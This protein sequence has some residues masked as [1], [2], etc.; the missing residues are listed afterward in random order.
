MEPE[1]GLSLPQA[2]WLAAGVAAFASV[3][4]FLLPLPK[5]LRESIT[6]HMQ[7]QVRAAG[8]A[9]WQ[10]NYLDVLALLI[11]MVLLYRLE[12]YGSFIGGTRQDPQVD[13]M[14]ILAPLSLLLGTAAIFLRVFPLF[15]DKAA[16][17]A[18]RGRG[19]PIVLAL[20]QASRDPRHVT[21]LVLLLMLAMALGIFSTSLDA[22]MARNEIDRSNYFA[23][24]D[25]RL[26]TNPITLNGRSIQGVQANTW[27]W[28]SE[29]SLLAGAPAPGLDILA[30]NPA[31]FSALA[32]FRSDF[33]DRPIDQLLYD[34]EKDWEDH[35][36][37]LPATVLPGK[38]AKMGLWFGLPFSLR[39][40]PDRADMLSRTRFEI[41][42]NS[43]DGEIINVEL[44]P[45][46]IPENLEEAWSFFQGD[47][48]DLKPEA[49]PLRLTSLWLQ[50]NGL[51]LG[52][53]EPLWLDDI[54][55][56]DR[57]T[58]DH[59]IV[60]S[61]EFSGVYDWQSLTQPMRLFANQSLSHS[62]NAGLAMY[63]DRTG[64]SPLRWYGVN[65]INDL[66]LQAIPA[67][68]SPKFLERTK[69]EV[70]DFV[71]IRIKVPGNIEW[72]RMTFRILG[73]ANYFPTMYE[74]K[75]AGFLVTLQKP[76]MEQIN[77][78]RF[79]P[80][81]SN[82]VLLKAGDS[83]AASQSL[84]RSGYLPEDFYSAQATLSD[85]RSN[86]LVIGLRSVT[87]FGYILTT[88]L[89]LVG[90]ASHFYLSTQ[91]R[92]SQYSILRALGLSP[93]QLYTTLL[94]EQFVL[95]VSGLT[96]GTLLGILLNQLIL[97]GLPLRLGDLDTIPPFV[98]QND[99]RLIFQV[100]LTLALAFLIS[101]G[102]AIFLLWK[103]QIHR[104][105]RIG[106]E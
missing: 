8:P 20:S 99:W 89:S 33:S 6:T 26:I 44:D 74:A 25:I 51:E 72:D 11:G 94:V 1:W 76:L 98:V 87:L 30:V 55:V 23:G 14:L 45:V 102:M 63:F 46:F 92:A 104:V 59:T 10:R 22:T 71:R 56:I 48:L 80:L 60:E 5:V 3:S 41:R 64:I 40:N 90:F 78:Y 2:A 58:G 86:T 62:G 37:P 12:L 28:R 9:W 67:L 21:R 100:Y 77:L 39:E 68:V 95:V 66:E 47:I 57:E 34:L 65:N 101:I 97:P 81:Q 24:A 73:R 61:F 50:S 16:E 36:L 84:L 85:L 18:G 38:P 83:D 49:Y 43:A 13:F 54:E 17:F 91:Q 52:D 35:R 53:F 70:G 106:E 93:G 105:L 75:D 103:V 79:F 88:V 27:I 32:S 42:L 15:L 29:A 82:E 96:L 4:S 31:N 7:R 69:L 19:L